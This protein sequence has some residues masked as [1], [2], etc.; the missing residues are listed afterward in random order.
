MDIVSSYLEA[1]PASK[2]K[3]VKILS[4]GPAASGKSCLIK[5]Y[6]ESKFTEEYISTIG[7]DYGVKAIE[8]SDI[9]FNFWDTA[10]DDVYFD[11][12]NE[13]YKDTQIAILVYDVSSA[14]TFNSLSRWYEELLNYTDH[15]V[16]VIIV[17][18]KID[19]TRQV[20][21]QA[22]IDFALKYGCR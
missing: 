7:I 14:E 8:S 21:T 18:N 11:I 9:R 1:R 10:G 12:R 3:R 4:I 13:F 6:C 2:A 19:K 15:P 5:R 17:G 16:A 20:S 22:G